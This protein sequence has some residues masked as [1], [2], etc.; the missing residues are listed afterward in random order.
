[1]KASSMHEVG[2]SSS[3]CVRCTDVLDDESH[4]LR[5][6][7]CI[8]TGPVPVRL[9][10]MANY[11]HVHVMTGAIKLARARLLEINFPKSP[12]VELCERRPGFSLEKNGFTRVK[13]L[14][15]FATAP[16]SIGGRG[17]TDRANDFCHVFRLR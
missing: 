16:R 14:W 4:W 15:P 10:A 1:M 2:P 9:A 3:P 6:P 8:S 13:Q 17:S 5:P 11:R 12:L 7:R